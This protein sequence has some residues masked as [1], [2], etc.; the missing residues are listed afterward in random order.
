MGF[1]PCLNKGYDDDDDDDDDDDEDFPRFLR[2][3]ANLR[4][5]GRLE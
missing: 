1:F 3:F 4:R 2:L 5:L